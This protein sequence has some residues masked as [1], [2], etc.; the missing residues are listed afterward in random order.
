MLRSRGAPDRVQIERLPGGR[1]NRAYRVETGTG[2]LFLKEYYHADGQRDRLA[3]EY[4]FCEFAWTAGL[5]TLPEPVA[6]DEGRHVALYEWI[7]G[8]P[9]AAGELSDSHVDAAIAFLRELNEQRDHALA[10]QL[11][12]A[13]E[14]C[15]SIRE[16]LECV[17]RRIARLQSLPGEDAVDKDAVEFVATELQPAFERCE[18][19]IASV[20]D[21]IDARIKDR[22]ISPSDFG[23]HNALLEENGANELTIRSTDSSHRLRFIDF[24]YAGWDDPAKTVCDF[25]C[26][27]LV[28]VPL[29]YLQRFVDALADIDRNP[30]S[31]RSRVRLLLPLYRIKW[32]G[33]MMNEFLPGDARRREFGGRVVTPER[34]AEQLTAARE[35]LRSCEC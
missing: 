13:A 6:K 10:A 12:N 33:I 25:F 29:A 31:F 35:F 11:P 23:F 22:W 4:A 26:Q 8:R 19:A 30:E 21:D 34:K 16:H 18:A 15:F 24:E 2:P 1:N 9:I 3:A 20:A 5:R 17:R 27:P 32:C 14:A 7:D 28:P